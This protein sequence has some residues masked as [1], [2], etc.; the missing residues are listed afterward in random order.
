MSKER[1]EKINPYHFSPETKEEVRKKQAYRCADCNAH[2]SEKRLT[3]HHHVPIHYAK[4]YLQKT[5]EVLDYISGKEN[6]IML[7][8]ECHEKQHEFEDLEFYELIITQT[9]GICALIEKHEQEKIEHEE[10]EER[11]RRVAEVDKTLA[12]KGNLS[13]KKQD[14]KIDYPEIE[15]EESLV[16]FVFKILVKFN[17]KKSFYH[18]LLD[19]KQK[20][21]KK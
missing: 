6:C 17:R 14:D 21:Y 18:V 3:A 20:K 5:Q 9:L 11:F 12:D 8:K 19:K 2:E 10:A 16:D 7:C 4:N 13:K 15:R 1:I